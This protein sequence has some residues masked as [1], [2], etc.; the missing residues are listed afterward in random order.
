MVKGLRR[1]PFTDESRVRFPYAVRKGCSKEQPF[2][3]SPYITY[4]MKKYF[5]FLL[6]LS[7]SV[8]VKGQAPAD[9]LL[10]H[11]WGVRAIIMAGQELTN[12]NESL[13]YEFL[14]DHTFI[15]ISSD[16]N[17]ERGTWAFDEKGKVIV[18]RIKKDK[19]YITK[20]VEGDLVI[21]PSNGQDKSNALG[22]ATAMK[23]VD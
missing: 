3:F 10:C 7:I 13:T 9:S 12:I 11:K 2:L 17:T 19:L 1:I 21:S 15:R 5:F 16:K 6:F 18:L 4:T 23:I 20:L 14:K 22:I 8:Y